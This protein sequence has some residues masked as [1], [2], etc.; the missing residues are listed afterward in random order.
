MSKNDIIS[1]HKGGIQ[2]KT[3][4]LN[5]DVAFAIFPNGYPLNRPRVSSQRPWVR[6]L[7]G[8]WRFHDV[9]FWE[10]HMLGPGLLRQYR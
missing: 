6:L 4:S 1:R 2:I 5:Q 7:Y 9:A 10:R 3:V 8:C